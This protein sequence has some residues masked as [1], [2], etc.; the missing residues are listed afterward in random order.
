MI[1]SY[2][3]LYDQPAKVMSLVNDALCRDIAMENDMLTAF[4]AILDT[5]NGALT[6][7][8]A[9]H[10][11]PILWNTDG[12]VKFLESGGP[13]FCGMGKQVYNEDCYTLK[14]GDIFVAVTDGITEAGTDKHSE[15]FG[16]E[17]II[18]SL[19]A[20]AS[21]LSE[22]IS[23]TIIMD[24]TEFANGALHDD[25]TVLLVKKLGITV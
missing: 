18:R 25:A 24:A 2:A 9:G 13:M 1:R 10:E 11:P 4:F 22:R 3:F 20:V 16:A 23:A 19:S 14:A 6:Y 17:G 12:N 8:N 7:S 15:Q 21:D 5:K